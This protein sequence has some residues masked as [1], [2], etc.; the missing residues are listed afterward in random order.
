[1]KR[2]STCTSRRRT[3]GHYREAILQAQR[4]HDDPGRRIIAMLGARRLV[5]R[6][7]PMAATEGLFDEDLSCR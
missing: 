4:G 2:C 3:S 1:M 6:V 5:P 7:S